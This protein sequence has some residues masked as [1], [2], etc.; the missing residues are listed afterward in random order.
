MSVGRYTWYVSLIT[1]SK[2]TEFSRSRNSYYTV[3][4]KRCKI[5]VLLLW[6]TNRKWC[7]TVVWVTLSDREGRAVIARDFFIPLWSSCQDL[8]W[9][10]ASVELN[11]S[12]VY[13]LAAFIALTLLVGRRRKGIRP[14]KNMGDGAGEHWLVWIE[15]CPAGWSVCLPLLILPCT[16]KSRSSLLAPAHSP[17]WSQKKGRKTVVCVCVFACAMYKWCLF[18]SCADVSGYDGYDADD[19]GEVDAVGKSCVKPASLKPDTSS[20]RLKVARHLLWWLFSI[21]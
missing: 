12:A 11:A 10:S 7:V 3:K 19:G 6:T 20:L 14:V 5:E 13:K 4:M 18:M 8:S 1:L 17:G 21:V 16:I 15:W 9:H 2:Q